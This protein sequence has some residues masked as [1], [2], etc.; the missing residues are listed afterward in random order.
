MN[1]KELQSDLV[2]GLAEQNRK[3]IAMSLSYFYYNDTSSC[4]YLFLGRLVEW[5]YVFLIGIWAN[6][7]LMV[8]HA[9]NLYWT[10]ITEPSIKLSLT[11]C[12]SVFYQNYISLS[13]WSC[14]I[15]SCA[16]A[17]YPGVS[18][19]FNWPSDFSYV[20]YLKQKHQGQ[21]WKSSIYL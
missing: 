21:G 4:Y 5:K 10:K 3:E 8:F 20:L 12:S 18:F 9:Y 11:N 7:I 17:L 15:S 6:F 16:S 2:V 14:K 19:Y 13:G 1:Y